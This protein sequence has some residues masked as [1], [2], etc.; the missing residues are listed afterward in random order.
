MEAMANRVPWTCRTFDRRSKIP[1]A[2]GKKCERADIKVPAALGAVIRRCL[3][4]NPADRYALAAELAADLRAVADNGPLRF[5]RE[6]EPSRTLRRAGETA[7]YSHSVLGVLARGGQLFRGR[8]TAATA[9]RREA[10]ARSDLEAGIRSES[11][12]EFAAAA[13]Q[14]ARAIDRAGAGGSKALRRLAAEAEHRRQN[15]I[16]AGRIRDRAEAF[17]LK[18]EP[19]RYRLI[20]GYAL[21]SA[22][23]ELGDAFAEFPYVFGPKPWSDDPELDR[24][25]TGRRKRLIE[26]VNEVLFLWVIAADQPGD[27]PQ[28]RQAAAI[29]ERALLFAEPQGPWCALKARYDGSAPEP[30]SI[31]A[32]PTAESNAR[33]CFEWG[34]LAL[35]DGRPDQALAWFERAVSLR[36]DQFWYQFAAAYHQAL[37]GDAGQAMA[38]YDA[39]LALRPAS[40]WV[41]FNRGQLGWSRMGGWERALADL[42]RARANPDGLDPELLA[43]ELGRVAERLGDYPSALEHYRELIAMDPASELAR[44]ARLNGARVK[45][46]LG[47][48]GRAGAWADY[49]RLVAEDPAD[50]A[51]RLGHALVA[52]RTGRPDVAETDLTRLLTEHPDEPGNQSARAEWLTARALARLALR[53]TTEAASDA[54]EAVRLAPSPGRLRVRLRLA[55]ATGCES[56]LTGLDPDDVDR[57]PAGGGPLIADLQIAADKLRIAAEKNDPR[58]ESTVGPSATMTLAALYSAL[59]NHSE[60]LLEADKAA[61]LEPLG[62]EVRLLRARIRR[63]A[64]DGKGAMADAASGLALAPGDARLQTLRGTL[65]IENGQLLAGLATLDQ[66]LAAGAGKS[67][68]AARARA[69]W[70]LDR[71]Q[72]SIAAWTLALRDDPE[73]ADAF[74]GR[75]RCFAGLGRWDP[76][77]ADLE[78]A[79]NWSFDRPQILARS[80]LVYAS[81]LAGRPNRL[82]RVFGLAL[83]AG[84]A[85]V[86]D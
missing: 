22:S 6:P 28:A 2:H 16:A 75:A 27:Q 42:D 71:C 8:R 36:P 14:F 57:L 85:C 26:E 10:L 32:R 29:C 68:H 33:A 69:L 19:I 11:A 41:L 48:A 84:L 13:A 78:S 59:G 9:L 72:D 3:H 35:L 56:E 20:T 62:S 44:R 18:I 86:R 30:S 58:A 46:E 50:S 43:L 47:P 31:P 64:G 53:R 15:A 45:L 51:V 70:E 60:A 5:A 79:V 17:F 40:S 54:N 49:E 66:S 23:T 61:A 25:D 81:C 63:R 80:A 37:H 52:L 39:A 38:H 67:A 73:D 7:A 24:L 83:R 4:P 55:I 1:G 21:K 76:A 34:L 74:L 65:L 12:G 77:L 82:S